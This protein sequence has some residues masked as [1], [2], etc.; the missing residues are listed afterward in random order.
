MDDHI[1]F[2][3]TKKEFDR[4]L[5]PFKTK[6]TSREVEQFIPIEFLE[7]SKRTRWEE[8]GKRSAKVYFKRFDPVQDPFL[9]K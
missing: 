3:F 1:P 5:S 9:N 6:Y 8:R 7:N 4:L 2:F